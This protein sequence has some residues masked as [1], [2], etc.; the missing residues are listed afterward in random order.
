MILLIAVHQAE[1][2]GLAQTRKRAGQIIYRGPDATLSLD[3]ISSFK[4]D[5]ER[6][7]SPIKTMSEPMS[8]PMHPT[9]RMTTTGQISKRSSAP[10][11]KEMISTPANKTLNVARI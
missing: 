9:K 6:L 2:S 11:N 10:K 1:H 5:S 3:A 7:I 4:A 8:E